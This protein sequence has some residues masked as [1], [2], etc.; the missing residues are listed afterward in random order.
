MAKSLEN[1]KIGKP[2]NRA[3]KNAG[4]ETV[5]Q[6]I[7]YSEKDLLSLHGFGPKALGILN[8]FLREN[9]LIL[10]GELCM[11]KNH[12]ITIEATINAPIERVW[13]CFT[14]PEHIKQWNSASDDWHTT[15]AEN[16]LRVGGKFL[17]RMEAKDGSFGFDFSGI[18]DEINLHETIAYTL[19]DE[20]RVRITFHGDD[21]KTEVIEAFDA[22]STNSVEMQ[23]DGWQSI[24][25]HFKDYVEGL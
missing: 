12:V 20:R 23:K 1:I 24:L 18:Y 3:L 9:D 25:D 2:A 4:I 14:E 22:E 16:D 11:S 7:D 21:N 17:S 5:D 13:K 8:T 6:L 10:K 15:A 19:G